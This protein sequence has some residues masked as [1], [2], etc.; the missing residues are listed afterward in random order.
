MVRHC[1][2]PLTWIVYE[3][4]P[5]P[6]GAGAT[7][8]GG[9]GAGGHWAVKIWAAWVESQVSK[10]IGLEGLLPVLDRQ[11][12]VLPAMICTRQPTTAGQRFYT[13]RKGARAQSASYAMLRQHRSRLKKAKKGG[14]N[15]GEANQQNK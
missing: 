5:P 6:Q 11:K 13:A 12:L 3:A 2:A 9:G 8:T 15:K 1:V 10:T 14:N 4:G 7:A